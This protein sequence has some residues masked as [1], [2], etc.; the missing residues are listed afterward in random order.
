MN[1]LPLF[2]ILIANYNNSKYLLECLNSVYN[3]TYANWEIV[4]VDD[5]SSDASCELYEKI[6]NDERIHVY[7]NDKNYGCG[8]TKRKCIEL[9]QGGIAGFLDPDDMLTENALQV[10]VDEHLRNPEASLVYSTYY[11]C[12]EQMN[13][14][15]VNTSSKH[16]P[17]DTDYLH[18]QRGA[19]HAFASFKIVKY[20]ASEGLNP[21][22]LRA[23]DQNLYYLLEEQGDLVFHNEPLYYYRFH[24]RSISIFQNTYKARYW[25]LI[26]IYEACVRRGIVQDSEQ[27]ATDLLKIN[28]GDIETIKQELNKYNYPTLKL[29]LKVIYK[30]ICRK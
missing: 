11:K 28:I 26:A 5:A 21:L 15:Y 7:I 13:V 23:V 2:S 17:I 14:E 8:Y 6:E 12:D 10:M 1:K 27:I 30:W 9:A 18:Y 20:R 25:H 22:F 4:I 16:L 3:Q 29:V 19:V 24:N